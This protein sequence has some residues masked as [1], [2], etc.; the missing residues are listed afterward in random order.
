MEKEEICYDNE[1]LCCFYDYSITNNIPLSP[2]SSPSSSLLSPSLSS[3]PSSL[4]SH[5]LCYKCI[6]QIY[7]KNSFLFICP[8]CFN[9]NIN[10]NFKINYNLL[11]KI[12]LNSFKNQNNFQFLTIFS[13]KKINQI[14]KE[15]R[16]KG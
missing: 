9:K 13:Y 15:G 1:C 14:I 5:S 3:S 4:C 11:N 6:Y 7:L 2:S 16:L 10:Y 12:N 8:L